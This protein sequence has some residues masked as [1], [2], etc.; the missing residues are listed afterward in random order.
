MSVDK[1]QIDVSEKGDVVKLNSTVN[2]PRCP[3]LDPQADQDYSK[4]TVV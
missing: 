3:Q 4:M 1:R 2:H